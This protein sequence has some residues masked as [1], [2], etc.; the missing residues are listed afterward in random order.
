MF[1]DT[2]LDKLNGCAVYG[3]FADFLYLEAPHIAHPLTRA[4]CPPSP[5]SWDCL[6]LLHVPP[7][8]AWTRVLQVLLL[9]VQFII[10]SL[11][12]WFQML[13]P[14]F[15]SRLS[16]LCDPDSHLWDPGVFG[17]NDACGNNILMMFLD[18][19]KSTWAQARFS[20]LFP[21]AFILLNHPVNLQFSESHLVLSCYACK[22]ILDSFCL[23][24]F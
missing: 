8:E 1:I 24:I 12:C 14:H 13:I 16:W 23:F 21:E 7:G 18:N 6:V 5:A 19:L 3:K 10:N 20:L 2:V 4:Q 22:D 15:V 11:S 17:G 9:S